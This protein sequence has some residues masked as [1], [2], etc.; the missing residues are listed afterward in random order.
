MSARV[1]TLSTLLA[2]VLGTP[3]AWVLGRFRFPGRALIESV[4]LLPLVLPPT[5]LG[6]YLL[7]LF[8][9]TAPAGSLLASLGLELAFTW[10]GAVL[11]AWVGSFGLFVRAAQAGFELVDREVEDAARTLG[12]SEWGVFWSVTLPL[13][14]RGIAAGTALAFCRAVGEFGITLMLAGN[15]PGLTQTIPLAIYDYVQADRM[16]EA[17]GLALVTL[18]VVAGLLLVARRGARIRF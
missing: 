8:N 2:L 4:V 18:A 12:R 6:Y 14:R 7:V 17:N 16:A 15:I 3:L 13:A 9:R 11:A 10:R 1:A 5:V